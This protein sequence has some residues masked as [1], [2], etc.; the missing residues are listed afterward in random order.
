MSAVESS[1]IIPV[2]NQWNLTRACLKGL[3]ATIK[4]RDVE[5]IIVDNGSTDVTPQA[6]PVLGRTLFGEAFRYHR[7]GNQFELR[8]GLQPGGQDGGRGISFSQ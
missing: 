4:D 6:C 1:I 7:S 5:V 3:A 2:F 8:P